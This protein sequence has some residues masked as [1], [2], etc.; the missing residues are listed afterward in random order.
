MFKDNAEVKLNEQKVKGVFGMDFLQALVMVDESEW[1]HQADDHERTGK[2]N[3][4]LTT[5]MEASKSQELE[6]ENSPKKKK[7]E[8][9]TAQ[10]QN[11][12]SSNKEYISQST[13]RDS[14]VKSKAFVKATQKKA[15]VLAS[16]ELE[17]SIN[18]VPFGFTKQFNQPSTTISN[19]DCSI[20][21]YSPTIKCQRSRN[22][23]NRGKSCQFKL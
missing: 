3:R 13:G 6:Y 21:K 1:N 4:K 11:K 19:I 5:V 16:V 10:K 23:F 22:K 18:N 17:G 2:C 7:S 12:N 20:N 8:E 15:E 14:A 9:S